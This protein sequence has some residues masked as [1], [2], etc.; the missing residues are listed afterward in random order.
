MGAG[1]MEIMQSCLEMLPEAE[2]A[3]D[4]TWLPSFP[5]F[6]IAQ[7]SR[8]QLILELGKRS[9]VF[10]GSPPEWEKSKSWPE[11]TQSQD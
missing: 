5:V 8:Y 10:K 3:G 7:V 6:L 9:I 1:T 4:A 2:R 11:G